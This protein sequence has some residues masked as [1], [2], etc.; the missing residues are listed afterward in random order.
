VQNCSANRNVQESMLLNSLKLV[1][2]HQKNYWV[3]FE[4]PFNLTN[5]MGK[6]LSMFPTICKSMAQ[7]S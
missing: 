6:K 1:T 7:I 2:G 3:E 4:S 5:D